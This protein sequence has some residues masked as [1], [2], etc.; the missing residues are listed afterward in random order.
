[1][2]VICVTMPDGSHW[3]VPAKI[4]AHQRATY[5]AQKGDSYHEEYGYT[6]SQDDELLDW[7][8]NNM[9]W[10]DVRGDAWPLPARD[11]P[12]DYQEGWANGDKQVI[13][14]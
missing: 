2:K 11:K 8:A 12:V 14:V 4:V 5:Y 13:E 9:N 7:A 6:M 10:D 3:A 1:M